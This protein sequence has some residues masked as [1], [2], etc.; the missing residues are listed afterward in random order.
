MVCEFINK[1]YSVTYKSGVEYS[2]RLLP[3]VYFVEC[4]GASGSHELKY[5]GGRGSFVSGYIEIIKPQTIYLYPGESG[6]VYGDVT[7][8]GGGSGMFR[9]QGHDYWGKLENIAKCGS[10]GGASDIRLIGGHWN[11]T[12]S[13]KSRIIVAA[14]GG[15]FVNYNDGRGIMKFQAHQEVV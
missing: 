6:K 7:F 13:L 9:G 3:G 1:T 5:E 8:N 2:C 11:N 15:G 14:G 10:G 12:E 4:W